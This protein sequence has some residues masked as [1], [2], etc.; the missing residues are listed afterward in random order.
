MYSIGMNK[1][2]TDFGFEPETYTILYFDNEKPVYANY[3]G[4]AID[5]MSMVWRK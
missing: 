1:T 2:L 4:F 3:K 5:N